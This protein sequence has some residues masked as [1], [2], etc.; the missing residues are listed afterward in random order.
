MFHR[1]RTAVFTALVLGLTA[2]ASM[3]ASVESSR[4][5]YLT[6]SKPV[7]LPGVTLRSG[8]YIFEVPDA[9]AAYDIVRVLSR[10]RKTVYFTAFTRSIDRPASMPDTE[11]VSFREAAPDAPAPIT[12]WWSDPLMGR[13]FIYAAR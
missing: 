13:Q 6:F 3:H 1:A 4:T 8:T 5:K 12:V 2:A 9:D 7:A 10:D 11:L